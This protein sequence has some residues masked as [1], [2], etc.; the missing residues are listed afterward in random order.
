MLM[1]CLLKY[2][3]IY[4]TYLVKVPRRLWSSD[5]GSLLRLEHGALAGL[6]DL[7]ELVVGDVFIT[8]SDFVP[9]PDDVGLREPVREEGADGLEGN[10]YFFI[11]IT[12]KR[13]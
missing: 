8:V 7:E 1:G 4:Y 3:F 5:K 12:I 2:I 11:L 13:K 10:K 6:E 9:N